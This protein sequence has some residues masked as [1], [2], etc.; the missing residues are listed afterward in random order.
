MIKGSFQVES[1]LK[2]CVLPGIRRGLMAS[3]AATANR[4]PETGKDMCQ[5]LPAGGHTDGESMLETCFL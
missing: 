1:S 3:D 2:E 4:R 5:L